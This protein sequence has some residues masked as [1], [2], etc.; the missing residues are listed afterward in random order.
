MDRLLHD[1]HVLLFDGDSCAEGR[2]PVS[3]NARPSAAA[4]YVPT[5]VPGRPISRERSG[6]REQSEPRE[7]RDDVRESRSRLA[8]QRHLLRTDKSATCRSLI[9][10]QA[11]AAEMAT[12]LGGRTAPK[13]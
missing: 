13:R 5:P 1:A 12:L 8:S 6:A 7:E 4:R 3:T 9:Q 11:E 2:V 10:L